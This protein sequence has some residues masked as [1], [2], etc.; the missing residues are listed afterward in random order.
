MNLLIYSQTKE[1]ISE[2]LDLSV[3][4]MLYLK[5]A[6][7]ES[8]V[9]GFSIENYLS[10]AE[11]RLNIGDI[12]L[13][14]QKIFRKNIE[15]ERNQHLANSFGKIQITLEARKTGTE[16][17]NKILIVEAF[18]YP[19]KLTLVQFKRML[20]DIAFV[21][22]GLLLDVVSKARSSFGW[23]TSKSIQDLSGIEEHVIINQLLSR[24]EPIIERINRDPG[25]C[26]TASNIKWRCYGHENFTN[27]SLI[28][29]TKNGFDPREKGSARPFQCD[30]QRKDISFDTWENRQIKA[31]CKWVAER[32]ALVSNKAQL[33][34]DS[35]TRDKQWR[36]LAPKGQVSLWDLE[37]APRL[38]VLEKSIR[39]CR[40]I[41]NKLYN[42][43]KLFK[44]LD[45]V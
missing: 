44:F 26:L 15:W 10:D 24:L 20:Q 6:F 27:R 38:S 45:G 16:F 29:I 30:I 35:I 4:K 43:P 36:K 19:S 21:C 41:Q 33:Q 17:W 40:K 22:K 31:F 13:L 2:A 23:I 34:I 9:L 8:T 25:S 28:Q 1:F 14:E 5:E 11:Y 18:S 39:S 32:A 3:C 42:Y 37:D 7:E 12:P